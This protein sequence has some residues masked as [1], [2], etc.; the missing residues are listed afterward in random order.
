MHKQWTHTHERRLIV[1][2][3]FDFCRRSI[4]KW[5]TTSDDICG[6]AE[7]SRDKIPPRLGD[8]SESCTIGKMEIESITE[9]A[10][11]RFECGILKTTTNVLKRIRKSN[12]GDQ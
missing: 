6:K 3:I 5:G 4:R 1:P 2:F 10:R 12:S 11:R 8:D 7:S 9:D